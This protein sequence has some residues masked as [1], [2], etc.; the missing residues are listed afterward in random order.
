M[1]KL[2][3]TDA[4]VLKYMS[5]KILVN[6]NQGYTKCSTAIVSGNAIMT[7][8][9]KIA[10]SFRNLNMDVLYLPPGDILLPGLNYGFIGG[11]CCLLEKDLMVFYGDLRNYK[12]GLEVL[13]FLKKHSV[14]PYYLS[15]GKLID[16]GSIFK[17]EI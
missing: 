17:I 4:T 7:S 15:P 1:H 3:S 13:S 10:E 11:C 8:D 9:I 2:N 16:R 5:D 14:N 6:V 12:H